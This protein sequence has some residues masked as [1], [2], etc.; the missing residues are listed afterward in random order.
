MKNRFRF[1]GP[2]WAGLAL[3]G[4][5]A[6]L[7]GTATQVWAEAPQAATPSSV[8][9]PLP[10]IETLPNGLQLV[11]F[12]SDHL[13]VVDMAVLIK[14]GSRYDPLGKSGTA[15]L[16]ASLLDRGA[17]GL[18]AQE[19]AK[20]VEMLGAS[21]YASADGD[22]FSIGMHGLAPDAPRLLELLGKMVVRPEFPEAEV[23]REH[24]RI[25]DRWRHIGDYGDTLAGIAYS[26][27]VSSGTPYGR[28]ELL[29]LKEFRGL[30]RSDV[31]SFHQTHF[32]PKNAIFMVVGRVDKEG[33]RKKIVEAFGSWKGEMPKKPAR[34]F[35]DPRVAAKP[36]QILIVERPGLTQA[37]VRMGFE[38]PPLKSPDHYSL[39]VAN[40]LLGEY[41]NSRLN[42]II[43]DKLGLS[44]GIGSSFGYSKDFAVF[45]IGS[46]TRNETVG[47]LIKKT[48]EIL[49]DL[50]KGPIPGDEVQ[51]AK[52]YLIG[53]FPLSVSTLGSVASRWLGGYVFDLG[54]GYLN[55]F[56]P[57]VTE[58]KPEQVL[59]AVGKHF[60]LE[61][62]R[63]VVAGNAAEIKK[64]L[65]AHGLTSYRVL[66][67]N[68]L[69]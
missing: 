35:T 24:A 54:P 62:L 56:V 47:Q 23:K 9:L 18:N 11:W 8:Q 69:L 46:A 51:M 32:T 59:S 19:I 40:A 10:E 17:G 63:I 16:V 67:A 31:V 38:A 14:S 48:Q 34:Q 60:P 37:A 57:K 15:E 49:R 52:D 33:F 41:F 25:L 1:S 39:T 6:I 53:G 5:S 29:S 61:R 21:R 4:V 58:T 55:E 50:K 36:G 42:S 26:R 43:R 64:S 45:T 30:K 44:Y 65:A 68:D 7:P 22:T 66:T 27:L 20:S 13:P 2:G 12:L 3:L 28:G